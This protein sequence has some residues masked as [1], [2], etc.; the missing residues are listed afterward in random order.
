MQLSQFKYGNEKNKD[1]GDTGIA[2]S[3]EKDMQI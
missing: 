1:K 2:D 3:T